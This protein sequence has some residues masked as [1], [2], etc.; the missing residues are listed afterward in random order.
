MR[1]FQD[2]QVYEYQSFEE[3][4]EFPDPNDRH[5]VAAALRARADIIVTYNLKD[6]PSSI[7]E[8]YGIIIAPHPDHF[9]SKIYDANPLQAEEGF[10][11]MVNRLKKPSKS[12]AEVLDILLRLNLKGAVQRLGHGAN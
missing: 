8:R 7:E 4:I 5:V 10:L 3:L 2:A 9:L 1:P 12:R 11:K 6:F